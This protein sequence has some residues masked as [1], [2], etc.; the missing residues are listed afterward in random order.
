MPLDPEQAWKEAMSAHSIESYAAFVERYPKAK[1]AGPARILLR[2]LRNSALLDVTARG[3]VGEV[4][5]LLDSGAE[6]DA[7]DDR[8]N[9]ALHLA[10]LSG[11]APA[12]FLLIKRGAAL[13]AIGELG[14]TPL[15]LAIH[16]D[17][18]EVEETLRAAGAP[19]DRT[20]R[21]GLTPGDMRQLP[22]VENVVAAAT[23]LL[24]P[25]TGR[26][27]ESGKARTLYEELR[28]TEPSLVV[29][30]LALKVIHAP[31]V[32][33]RALV[34]AVKLGIPGSEERLNSVLADYGDKSMAED[35]I[36]SG[37]GTLARGGQAW[38]SRNGYSVR[39]GRGSHRARW[40][41]F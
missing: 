33:R 2:D 22:S 13:D 26:W 28:N 20:N 7:R 29:N 30:S 15:H 18:R 37:S 35:F 41:R 25:A 5:R 17:E 24:D 12:A 31:R 11:R 27:T 36:N 40:G 3:D 38:A 1:Q 14:N 6:V 39:T 10:I 8:G 19:E 34:L 16:R 21:Y 23:L 9:T 32:R 4:T